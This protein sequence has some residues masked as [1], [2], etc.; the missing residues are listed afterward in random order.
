MPLSQAM[1]DAETGHQLAIWAAKKNLLFSKRIPPN[2]GNILVSILNVKKGQCIFV[3][4]LVC[5][6]FLII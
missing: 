4:G 6:T 1:V 2:D 3:L 5:K